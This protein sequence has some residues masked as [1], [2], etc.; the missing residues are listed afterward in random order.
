MKKVRQVYNNPRL[1]YV[2]T[3]VEFTDE[4]YDSYNKIGSFT[5]PLS[6]TVDTL[7]SKIVKI[8][9][10]LEKSFIPNDYG[11]EI[12]QYICLYPC[13]TIKELNPVTSDE[14]NFVIMISDSILYVRTEHLGVSHFDI[15]IHVRDKILH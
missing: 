2:I 13:L 10:I 14:V 1:E 8:S 3:P 15:A 6:E 12:F 9:E 4:E 7:N 5:L 11:K